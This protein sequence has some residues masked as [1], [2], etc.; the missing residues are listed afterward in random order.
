MFVALPPDIS[1]CPAVPWLLFA[2]IYASDELPDTFRLTVLVDAAVANP[3]AIV[4]AKDTFF[5][6]VDVTIVPSDARFLE[7]DILDTHRYS[8]N[9]DIIIGIG[10]SPQNEQARTRNAGI[11]RHQRIA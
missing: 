11:K 9:L 7:F 4:L 3:L 5:A 8:V 10:R 6:A 1:S 2:K